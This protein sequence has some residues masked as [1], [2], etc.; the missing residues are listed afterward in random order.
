MLLFVLL[1]SPIFHFFGHSWITGPVNVD[2]N[3]QTRSTDG[4]DLT[5]ARG[6]DDENGNAD[7]QQQARGEE[8]GQ[9][10]NDE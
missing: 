9:E 1:L 7:N 10:A 2:N 8:D 3:S 5:E 4:N 6:K